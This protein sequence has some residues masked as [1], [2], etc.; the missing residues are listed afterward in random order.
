MVT[1]NTFLQWKREIQRIVGDGIF[2]EETPWRHPIT[3]AAEVY[4][5]ETGFNCVMLCWQENFQ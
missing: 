2:V 1:G 3:F 4:K 5:T